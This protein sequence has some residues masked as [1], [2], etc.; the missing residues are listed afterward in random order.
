MEKNSPTDLFIVGEVNKQELED[1]LNRE[2]ETRRAIKMS[3]LSRED[4]IYRLKINDKFVQD[5][6]N[7]PENFV[8]VN[9]LEKYIE[10]AV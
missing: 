8:A 1:F 3:I 6:V 10:D 5:L 9:K 4:F 7:D 2:I